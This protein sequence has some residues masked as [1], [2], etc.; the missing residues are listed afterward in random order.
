M[1]HPSIDLTDPLALTQAL[2]R[3]PSVTPDPKGCFTLITAWLEALGFT[4]WREVFSEA[5]THDTE[6]L[7]ARRGSASP[8]LCFA[9]HI[10]VVPP[11]NLSQWDSP[12]FEPVVRDGML[13]GRG[14]EDMKGAIGAMIAG[15][16]RLLRAQPDYPAT[17]SFLL[18]ADEE[19]PALNGTCKM[20]RWMEQKNETLDFCIVGEPT[21]PD[22]LGEMAKLGRRGSLYGTLSVIGKQGHAAYPDLADNPI[23]RLVE[24]LRLLE[25]TP[26]DQGN[27]FFQPSNLEV[28]TIEVGND[29]LNVIPSRATA[30]F[31]IRF[32]NEHDRD[33]IQ[34]WVRDVCAR[35]PGAYD[36]ALRV[37]GEPFLSEPSRWSEMLVAAI[38]AVTGRTPQLS[39]SGGTSDARFIKDVCPVLEFGLTGKTIHQVNECVSVKDVQM[40]SDVYEAFLRNAVA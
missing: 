15:V 18:T 10:D 40:L 11:G 4:V 12:P 21:N 5:G 30:L 3:E 32:N 17:L 24:M 20:L 28:T 2:I 27:Q 14:A 38:T 6:N 29:A 22:H 23:P 7:Y 33:S 13:Y 34:R 35:V 39:T 26:I 36:L 19:G 8:N 1:S 25:V 31:N 16:A 37:T 9:G